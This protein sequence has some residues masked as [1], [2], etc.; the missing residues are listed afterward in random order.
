MNNARSALSAVIEPID[1]LTVGS[2]P[3]IKRIMK[4]VFKT[5]PSLPKYT[6]TYDASGV[7]KYFSTRPP[8]HLLNIQELTWKLATLMALLSAQ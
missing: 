2:H 1:G 8:N 3:L 6:V 7:L 4:G 5:K